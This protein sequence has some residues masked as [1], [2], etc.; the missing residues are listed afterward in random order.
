[1]TKIFSL[2]EKFVLTFI[3]K[4]LVFK[5]VKYY[6]KKRLIILLVIWLYYPPLTCQYVVLLLHVLFVPYTS[7]SEKK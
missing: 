7:K 4:C 2:P 3:Y 1:M 5:F 6:K